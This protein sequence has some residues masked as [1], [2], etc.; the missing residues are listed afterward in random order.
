MAWLV[1]YLPHQVRLIQVE[2]PQP[3]IHQWST[4][5]RQVSYSDCL[6]WRKKF[7]N[8]CKEW[9]TEIGRGWN[10]TCRSKS[11]CFCGFGGTFP[12]P[13]HGPLAVVSTQASSHH[14]ASLPRAASLSPIATSLLLVWDLSR[15][16]CSPLMSCLASAQCRRH[17]SGW[18][19]PQSWRDGSS[20]RP[21]IDSSRC[22]PAWACLTETRYLW[23]DQ[24]G[25]QRCRSRLEWSPSGSSSAFS[26]S[27]AGI[28][29]Q[30]LL[31]SR[32]PCRQTQPCF[33]QQ[34]KS[35]LLHLRMR[36][37]PSGTYF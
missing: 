8:C 22:S 1:N 5:E 37:N 16:Q 3:H 9:R 18:P 35:K 24:A 21:S 19:L 31:R 17:S 15:H 27:S 7:L 28:A 36:E 32:C 23:A 11:V 29:P 30:K 4:R 2:Q 14:A 26:S 10:W 6:C 33:Q 34:H 25:V 13:A 12:F 20:R